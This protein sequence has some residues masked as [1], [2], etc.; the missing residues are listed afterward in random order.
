MAVQILNSE[1][2]LH[3]AGSKQIELGSLTRISTGCGYVQYDWPR[4]DWQPCTIIE[5]IEAGSF[6]LQGP[7]YL[8]ITE[9]E[10]RKFL[11]KPGDILLKNRTCAIELGRTAVFNLQESVLHTKYL[12]LRPEN[13]IES[14]MLNRA[15]NLLRSQGKINQLANHRANLSY[16]NIEDLKRLKITLP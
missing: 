11:I 8:R 12:L 4:E 7:R 5:K 13:G 16:I 10:K 14:E 6:L 1:K 15:L 9:R 3:L 2:T